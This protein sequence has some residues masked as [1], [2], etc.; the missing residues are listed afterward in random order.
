[1]DRQSDEQI[2][3]LIQQ[4]AGP[5]TEQVRAAARASHNEA[6]FRTCVTRHIEDVAARLGV[7][8]TLR[9]EYT[10]ATGRADAVYN[11]V[12]IE[13]EPPGSLHPDLS[14]RQHSARGQSG[15]SLH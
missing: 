13:Y 15:Q 4:L 5:F 9:E 10:L 1:M 2:Y 7:Q 14:H 3:R 12:V 8:L 6:E 11:R